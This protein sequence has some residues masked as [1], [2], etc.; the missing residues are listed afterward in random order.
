M[1]KHTP[2]T[3]QDRGQTYIFES[4]IAILLLGSVLFFVVI[5][6]QTATP[7]VDADDRQLQSDLKSDLDTIVD[8]S[9]RDGSL[10]ASI[11]NWND[12]FDRFN[13]SETT[14]SPDNVYLALPQGP[15]G[16]RLY[17]LRSK[18]SDNETNIGVAVE[19]VP[20]QNASS[21]P[22]PN[23]TFN[24]GEDGFS[25]I[26]AGS[27]SQNLV[28]TE[29]TVVLYG[30]DKIRATPQHFQ[31]DSAQL[32]DTSNR[33]KLSELPSDTEYP[34]PPASQPVDDDD[35]YNVVTIRVIAWF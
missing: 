9:A 2:P 14:Q 34:I 5:G 27:A 17:Q 32:H 13:D 19:I 23:A 35:I 10:K 33:T 6:L 28:V 15:F 22:D 11:L 24:Q 26:S 25:F 4:L 7:L 21:S 30:D 29:R 1:S 12:K 20:S 16:D 8:Q 31:T 3:A 18:H